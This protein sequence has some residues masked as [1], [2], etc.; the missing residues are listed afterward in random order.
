MEQER[1]GASL[2]SPDWQ[3][4]GSFSLVSHA[5][6]HPHVINCNA[7]TRRWSALIKSNTWRHSFLSTAETSPPTPSQSPRSVLLLDCHPPFP[8]P[9]PTLRTRGYA[10]G[11]FSLLRWP[12]AAVRRLTFNF[13]PPLRPLPPPFTQSHPPNIPA[14]AYTH[15]T[16]HLFYHVF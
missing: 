6:I 3:T 9:P 13:S 15:T 1:W 12:C 5:R 14:H 2:S 7:I 16:L 8:S 10:A 11:P 4:T